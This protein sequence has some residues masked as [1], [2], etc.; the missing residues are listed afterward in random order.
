M[1]ALYYFS[2][3]AMGCTVEVQLQTEAD[4]R[5]LLAALPAQFDALEDQLSRFRPHSELMQ[6]NARAGEWVTVSHELFENIANAKQAARFTNGLYNPLVLPA[7]IANGYDRS[8]ELLDAT[9]T[10]RPAKL[11]DWHAIGLRHGDQAV[12]LPAGAAIDLG[13]IAKGWTAALIADQL[14]EF[15]SCILSLGG[16]IAVRG[17]PVGEI[18]WTV[19]IADPV[20]GGTL[21]EFVLRDTHVVTSGTDYRRWQTSDGHHRHHIIDP[22][23]G[24]SAESDVVSVSIIHPHAPTAEACAKAVLLLGSH[25][26]LEWL[27]QQWGAAGIVICGSGAV[28][29]TSNWPRLLE[30]NYA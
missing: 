13:G 20:N 19:A 12:R 2:F 27:N 22:R 18:G 28:L 5:A 25:A 26:G 21:D 17:A 29:A 15:G 16:D 4:G 6:L 30:R 10:T 9:A 11:G 8:F 24:K 23:T 3:R 7:M 14:A 1:N